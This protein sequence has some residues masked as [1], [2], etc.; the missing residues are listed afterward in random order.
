MI[1]GGIL[2][3]AGLLGM[4]NKKEDIS[5]IHH[6]PSDVDVI[7]FVV[8]EKRLK[9]WV[10]NVSD[11][12]QNYRNREK[13]SDS[14]FQ[15]MIDV[16][17]Q[18]IKDRDLVVYGGM[19]LND[20]LPEGNGP[21]DQFYD[22]SIEIP[23]YDF[24]SQNA[25]IDAKDL[26]DILYKAGFEKTQA[27]GG[28]HEGTFKVFADFEPIADITQMPSNLM[29][30]I[31]KDARIGSYGLMYAGPKFL[32][33]DLHKQ[34]AESANSASRWPKVFSRARRIL[35][36]YPIAV[37][38]KTR[39][40][41]TKEPDDITKV[42][43]EK[44]IQ[45][46][47][48]KRQVFFGA[49][50]LAIYKKIVDTHDTNAFKKYGGYIYNGEKRVSDLDIISYDGKPNAAKRSA[51]E[52][53]DDLLVDGFIGVRV[54]DNGSFH[55]LFDESYSVFLKDENIVTFYEPQLCY[56]YYELDNGIRLASFDT[57]LSLMFANL[58]KS[59]QRTAS[60]TNEPDEKVLCLMQLLTDIIETDGKLEVLKHNVVLDSGSLYI[61]R[62]TTECY[63]PVHTLKDIMAKRSENYI[64][65]L[66]LEKEGKWKDAEKLKSWSHNPHTLDLAKRGMIKTKS[67]MVK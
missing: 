48:R 24:Y 6:I 39:D 59:D 67:W 1:L 35:H 36:H 66:M 16:V 17:I 58:F 21:Y 9:A 29:N 20:S 28:M 18:F 7:P 12:V 14:K 19:A 56:S 41:I 62:F 11:D 3:G 30:S 31:R 61:P 64:N 53:A 26:A 25:L 44:A 63:G 10:E 49:T 27:R 4:L 38:C 40:F 47:K 5:K 52:L 23:D 32:R 55:E 45:F 50:T 51:D 22:M 15:E 43:I 34:L 60:T 46:V 33:V 57:S 65:R 8:E 2:I 37:K 42:A 54:V 13:L